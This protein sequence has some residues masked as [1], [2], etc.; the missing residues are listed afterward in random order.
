[1]KKIGK[2]MVALALVISMFTLTSAACFGKFELTFGKALESKVVL[3]EAKPL[4]EEA[5]T[6]IRSVGELSRLLSP[7]AA[8]VP[9][10]PAPGRPAMAV[11]AGGVAPGASDSLWSARLPFGRSSHVLGV[12]R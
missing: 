4:S 5:G 6:I 3:D 2:K 1:M 12:R 8:A 7:A 10:A 11:S 9:A